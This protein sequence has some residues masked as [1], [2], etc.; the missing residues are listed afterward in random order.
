MFI[1]A[2]AFVFAVKVHKFEQDMY[3]EEGVESLFRPSTSRN[4]RYRSI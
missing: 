4:Y 2:V 3:E 1:N